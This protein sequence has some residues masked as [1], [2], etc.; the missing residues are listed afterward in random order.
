[1][2]LDTALTG[3]SSPGAGALRMLLDDHEQVR[4]LAAEYRDAVRSDSHAAHV[5]LATL[6][7]QAELHARVE[8]DVFY[9]AVRHV[10]PEFVRQAISDHH[11]LAARID[12]QENGH[13]DAEA[14]ETLIAALLRHLDAEERELFP[15]VEARLAAELQAIGEAMARRKSELTRDIE[16]MEGPAT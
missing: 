3:K 11:T 12:E 5:A 7:M 8:D 6:M 1:M 4:R 9:P 15:Q 16:D 13:A 14:A 10:A 2:D